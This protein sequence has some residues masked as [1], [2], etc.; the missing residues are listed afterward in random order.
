MFWGDDMIRCSLFR[1]AGVLCLTIPLVGLSPGA[2]SA[3]PSEAAT[4]GTFATTCAGETVHIIQPGNGNVGWRVDAFGETSRTP[5]HIKLVTG[6]VYA[7]EHT[8]EPDVTPVFEFRASFGKRVGQGEATQCF[9]TAVQRDPDGN[10]V[11]VFAVI[12]ATNL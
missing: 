1:V 11:T 8:T 2:A 9:V 12:E 3:A 4:T 7:G 6:S 10:V 5:N